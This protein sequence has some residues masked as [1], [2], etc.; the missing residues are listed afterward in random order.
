MQEDIHA[1]SASSKPKNNKTAAGSSSYEA[2]DDSEL[3]EIFNVKATSSTFEM[4]SE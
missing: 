4:A 2:V 1:A 3:E